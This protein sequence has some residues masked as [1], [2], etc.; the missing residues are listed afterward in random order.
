[1][2]SF[3][4]KTMTLNS[5]I[6]TIQASPEKAYGFLRNIVRNIQAPDIPDISN[7][8]SDGNCCSFTMKDMVHC[9]MS[10]T[11]DQPN[12]RVSYKID[13]DKGISADIAFLIESGNN[14]T[15]Q[16]QTEA[17]VDI[18]VFLQPM[19]KAPLTQAMEKAM[20]SLKLIIERS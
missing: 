7:W 15:C 3:F 4:N 5:N 12:K 13:T 17:S 9:S 19:I 8:R 20:G 11:E 10:L 6:E 1:M 18:P 16:L 14:D 2:H